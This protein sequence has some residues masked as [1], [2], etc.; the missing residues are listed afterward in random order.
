MYLLDTDIIVELRP[1]KP[2]QSGAVLQWAAG[3]KLSSHFISSITIF[4]VEQSLRQYADTPE[5]EGLR[6]WFEGVRRSFQGRIL[7]FSELAALHCAHMAPDTGEDWRNS[8]VASIAIEHDFTLVTMRPM[9][10]L[11]K[12]VRLLNPNQLSDDLPLF[13]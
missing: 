6:E 7:P 5:A 3:T 1:N 12:G 13:K 4:E 10:F 2:S 11:S 9:S 8:I